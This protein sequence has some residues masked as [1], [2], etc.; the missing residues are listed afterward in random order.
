VLVSLSAGEG[1]LTILNPSSVNFP[2]FASAFFSSCCSQSHRSGTF[3]VFQLLLVV[4]GT[5]KNE[6]EATRKQNYSNQRR[7]EKCGKEKMLNQLLK[8]KLLGISKH[9]KRIIIISP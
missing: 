1:N 3:Y 7:R 2:I 6:K 9:T 4:V 8:M 5:K